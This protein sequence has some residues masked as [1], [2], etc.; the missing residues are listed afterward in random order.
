MLVSGGLALVLADSVLGWTATYW[1]MAALMAV[2]VLATWAAPEPVRA[3]ARSA[4]HRAG[5]ARA[6]RRVLRAARRLAAARAGRPLQAGRRIRRQPVDGVPDPR[7]W[8]L[9]NRCR[10]D[11]QGPRPGRDH[12]RRARRRSLDGAA[13][14]LPLAAVVWRA[15]GG[16]QPRFHGGRPRR[17][18]LSVDDRGDRRRKP[19]RRHGHRSLRP[20]C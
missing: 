2:G 7:C 15:A 20:R 5:G 3:G 14:P 6:A 8:F 16:H 13:S 11:Q 18:A 4:Y 10:R 12:P 1:L 17:Q 19:V 9:G